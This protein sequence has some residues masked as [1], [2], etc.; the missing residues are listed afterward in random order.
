MNFVNFNIKT[1]HSVQQMTVHALT[2]ALV[3][4]SLVAAQDFRHLAAQL[5]GKIDLAQLSADSQLL[6]PEFLSVSQDALL[7][8]IIFFKSEM[9]DPLTRAQRCLSRTTNLLRS[10]IKLLRVRCRDYCNS[11][12]TKGGWRATVQHVKLSCYPTTLGSLRGIPLR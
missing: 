11:S 2:L 9:I 12:S 6:Q 1:F 5:K 10:L 4:L 8:K 7:V 3:C